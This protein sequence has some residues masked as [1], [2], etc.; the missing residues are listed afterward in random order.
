MSENRLL[1]NP[2]LPPEID[3]A[4]F[5]HLF[6]DLGRS[7][8]DAFNHVLGK[9]PGTLEWLKLLRQVDRATRDVVS[10]A[11]NCIRHGPDSPPLQAPLDEAFPAARQLRTGSRSAA[12]AEASVLLDSLASSSPRILG[13]LQRVTLECAMSNTA[14]LEPLIPSLASFLGRCASKLSHARKRL[15]NTRSLLGRARTQLQPDAR[16]WHHGAAGAWARCVTVPFNFCLVPSKAKAVSSQ[17]RRQQRQQ[18]AAA[19]AAAKAALGCS[20]RGL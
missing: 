10:Q 8:A 7:H 12:P 20:I 16:P 17:Q 3:A 18:A 2:R 13:K 9:L 4:S 19:T 6:V 5:W 1:L 14:P 15:G 11:V